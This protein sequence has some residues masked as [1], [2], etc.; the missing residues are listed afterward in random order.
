VNC[1]MNEN[2]VGIAD[3]K[4]TPEH[5]AEMIKMIKDGTIS[6]KIAKKVFKES[7]ENGTDPKNYVEDK[8]MLQLSD[9]SVLGPMVTTVVD[10][11]PQSV[12]GLKNGKDRAT[13]LLVGQI[14]TQTRGKAKTKLVNQL[15]NNQLQSR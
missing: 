1:Y 12:E 9:V 5:L 7:I 10:D 8:G 3:I 13:G 14:M 11:N 15:L 4:L 2:Q 6:S